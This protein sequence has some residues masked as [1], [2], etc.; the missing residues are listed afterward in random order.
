VELTESDPTPAVTDAD[1]VAEALA[2]DPEAPVPP[3][4]VSLWT[5][6]DPGT[7]APLP[8]WYM[9]P[10]IRA[11][12]LTGWRRHLLRW[13]VALIIASFLAIN[14]AGLCNTYGQLHF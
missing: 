9:P 14:A 7:T 8:D 13:N 1:L 10:P 6:T 11:R 12:V 5:L 2:A 3:D 4:A